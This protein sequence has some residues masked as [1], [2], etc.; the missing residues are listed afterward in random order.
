LEKL[1][2][3]LFEN[4]GTAVAVIEGN[5][6]ISRV[7]TEFEKFSGYSRT[8]VEGAKNWSEFVHNGYPENMGESTGSPHLNSLDRMHV[9]K[10]VDRQTRKNRFMTAARIRTPMECGIPDGY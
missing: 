8:D 1:Y 9:F 4:T 6:V 3:I 10:F 5:K 7:N 2:W